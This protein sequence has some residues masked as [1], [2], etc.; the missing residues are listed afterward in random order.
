MIVSSYH[1]NIIFFIWYVP[2]NQGKQHQNNN[3]TSRNSICNKGEGH[4]NAIV[5]IYGYWIYESFST[6]VTGMRTS[7]DV[8]LIPFFCNVSKLFVQRKSSPSDHGKIDFILP[9]RTETLR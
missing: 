5:A 3:G 6:F 9:Q 1:K 8:N 4:V 7:D 2:L